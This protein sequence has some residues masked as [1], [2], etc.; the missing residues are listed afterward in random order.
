MS[1]F[2][3][4][5][6]DIPFE[7][8][9]SP[10]VDRTRPRAKQWA[11]DTGFF[12]P[13]PGARGFPVWTEQTFDSHDYVLF[14]GLVLPSAPAELFGLAAD[15]I[16][17]GFFLDDYFLAA[18]GRNRDYA[19]AKA[20]VERLP[21]FM[22]AA[23]TP[24]AVPTNPIELGLADLWTRTAPSMSAKQ[25]ELFSAAIVS[26][27]ESFLWE[28]HNLIQGRLPDPVDFV[29]M[30]RRTSFGEFV[31]ALTRLLVAPDLS[32]KVFASRAMGTL[33]ETCMDVNALGNDIISYDNEIHREGSTNNLVLLT[34]QF[35]DCELQR[36]VHIVHDLM[37]QRV[38]Q[39]QRV[40]E[41]E[42][43]AM[44]ED[45]GLDNRARELLDQYVDALRAFTAGA[46]LWQHNNPRYAEP[47]PVPPPAPS[48]VAVPRPP[49]SPDLPV[50]KGDQA[51][52][53]GRV[54]LNSHRHVP[55][56]K[57][58]P[59]PL[60]KIHMPYRL[61]LNP[62]LEASRAA[63]IAWAG[64]MGFY[65]A[66]PGV[67]SVPLWSERENRG[68]DF[69]LC[70][71]GI[72][73]DCGREE[74]DLSAEWLTWGTYGDDYYPVVFGATR[75]IDTGIAQTR[76]L[77]EFMPLDCVQ[78]AVAT[79]PVEKGL[80]DLWVRTAGPMP[81][82]NRVKFRNSIEMM[83]ESWLWELNNQ[84]QHRV[85]DP[86]DY[87]EMR[88]KTFGS[89]LT[90]S[91]ARLRPDNVLPDEIFETTPM[92]E[93]Q[94]A[95]EDYACFLNDIFSYQKEM[96]YEGEL[97]NMVIV[98]QDF[99]NTDRDHAVA[100]VNDLMTLRIKEF[101]RVADEDL[102]VVAEDFQLDDRQRAGL[103]K[104][105]EELQDWMAAILHWH[106]KT[107]RYKEPELKL[108]YEPTDLPV[109]TPSGLGTAA[110]RIPAL[111]GMEF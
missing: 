7:A 72:D 94:N 19:G 63:S 4:P 8:R 37:R 53:P 61:Q 79:N 10:H 110:V 38:A 24:A 89:D 36:A 86:V 26:T 33:D 81:E 98:V 93:L 9:M 50:P 60:P 3:M 83:L 23:G 31:V 30:R 99:L 54:R 103:R 85:P 43:P 17:W 111:T 64:E 1:S 97:H 27:A 92:R 108:R 106:V 14:S 55:F 78:T 105:V 46:F 104:H 48:S 2:D 57:V 70:S 16:S 39:F 15:W 76:R 29:E 74:L 77:S 90:E 67:L 56:Q 35:L 52:A 5:V 21:A 59:T 22:S 102:P 96:Q 62:H 13:Q 45:L 66:V 91:L 44:A 34:Q 101:Q 80:A 18:F 28:L 32:E 12:S 51:G 47:L 95:A 65:D 73:P 20:F 88:R 82:G 6:F 41:H 25:R 68:F 11:R 100:I 109:P 69:A 107:S 71:A 58:G 40:A 84:F 75:R 87:I 49:A 42:L